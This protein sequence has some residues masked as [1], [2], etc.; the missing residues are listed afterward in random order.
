MSEDRRNGGVWDR[1]AV[2]AGDTVAG[3]HYESSPASLRRPER[4]KDAATRAAWETILFN[5]GFYG[6]YRR[7]F[8]SGIRAGL[9]YRKEHDA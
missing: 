9:R 5:A 8:E 4:R 2:T 1:R 7:C 3:F 6:D